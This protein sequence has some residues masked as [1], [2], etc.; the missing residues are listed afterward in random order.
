MKRD[1]IVLGSLFAL[2]VIEALLL[3]K[4]PAIWAMIGGAV[5]G[6]AFLGY[7]R[8]TRNDPHDPDGAV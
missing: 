2:I 3:H 7:R 5:V 4:W 8:I 6:I 1:N